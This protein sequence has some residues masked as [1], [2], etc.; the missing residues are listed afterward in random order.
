MFLNIEVLNCPSWVQY[1]S[2]SVRE[3]RNNYRKFGWIYKNGKDY[4]PHCVD[5]IKE[6]DDR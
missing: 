1:P 6:I 5:R 3:T 4:C 2:K